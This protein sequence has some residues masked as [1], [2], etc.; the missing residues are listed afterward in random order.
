MSRPEDTMA[1]DA[2]A[3]LLKATYDAQVAAR[4]PA[5]TASHGEIVDDAW[6][7]EHFAYTSALARA[8]SCLAYSS[9]QH[10]PPRRTNMASTPCSKRYSIAGATASFRSGFRRRRA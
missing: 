7:R 3:A 5:K 8:T 10:S 1:N 4:G 6:N 9:T 2:A